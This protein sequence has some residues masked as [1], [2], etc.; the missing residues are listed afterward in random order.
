MSG[1]S[2]HRRHQSS[3]IV[4]LGFPL[5]SPSGS[6]IVNCSSCGNCSLSKWRHCGFLHSVWFLCSVSPKSNFNIINLDHMRSNSVFVGNTRHIGNEIDLAGSEALVTACSCRLQAYSQAPMC[7]V[8]TLVSIVTAAR[9]SL[10]RTSAKKH[11]SH[12][13]WCWHALRLQIPVSRV[14]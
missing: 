9:G 8:A 1:N 2:Q 11:F 6:C 4:L 3:A 5:P 14:Q 10:F 7:L 13:S 12:F